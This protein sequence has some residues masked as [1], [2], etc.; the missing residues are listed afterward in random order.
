MFYYQE[1]NILPSAVIYNDLFD[2]IT[3]NWY[4]ENKMGRIF[5]SEKY[6]RVRFDVVF[7][8]E[9][10]CESEM[11]SIELYPQIFFEK[12]TLILVCFHLPIY[13]LSRLWVPEKKVYLFR[14]WKLFRKVILE[15]FRPTQKVN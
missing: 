11:K 6:L 15:K 13:L 7:E 9:S 8:S 3:L 2:E 5:F 12:K 14:R 1:N 10:N 4:H